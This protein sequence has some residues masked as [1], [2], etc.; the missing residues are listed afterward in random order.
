LVAFG[1][2]F[3]KHF[4]ETVSEA[5]DLTLFSPGLRREQFYRSFSEKETQR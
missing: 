5:A 1:S 2:K 4:F 3:P